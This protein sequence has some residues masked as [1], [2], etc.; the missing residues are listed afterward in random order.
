MTVSSKSVTAMLLNSKC[1]HLPTC[2]EMSLIFAVVFVSPKAHSLIKESLL[3][4]G[5]T[6]LTGN[7]NLY[8]PCCKKKAKT[9]VQVSFPFA[10]ESV[11]EAL[12][13]VQAAMSVSVCAC[14]NREAHREAL[15][16]RV[17]PSQGAPRTDLRRTVNLVREKV[18]TRILARSAQC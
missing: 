14:G 13:S 10:S 3:P 15:V 5:H 7:R 16:I 8:G 11:T 12:S 17:C 1:T 4:F 9:A 2:L 18:R 6:D